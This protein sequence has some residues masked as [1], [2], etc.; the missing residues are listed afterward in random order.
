[1]R[2]SRNLALIFSYIYVFHRYPVIGSFLYLRFKD[3]G[4]QIFQDVASDAKKYGKMMGFF[5]GPFTR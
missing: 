2:D 5:V 4:S 3:F 1:M